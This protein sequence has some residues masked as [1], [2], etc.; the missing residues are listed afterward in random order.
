MHTNKNLYIVCVLA[1]DSGENEPFELSEITI[2]M[3]IRYSIYL[4]MLGMF[5][6]AWEWGMETGTSEVSRVNITSLPTS[7]CSAVQ[8][9][10]IEERFTTLWHRYNQQRI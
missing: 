1:Q 2:V 10:V 7:C 8:A 9:I 3:G 4:C 5:Y 6:K